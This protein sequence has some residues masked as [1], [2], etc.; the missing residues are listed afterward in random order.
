MLISRIAPPKSALYQR[1]ANKIASLDHLMDYQPLTWFGL[2]SIFAAGMA[3]KGGEID[4]YHY[5]DWSNWLIGIVI[6]LVLTY[7]VS[8]FL[9][10]PKRISFQPSS[11]PIRSVLVVTWVGM[12]LFIT[13]WKVP[14]VLNG[15]TFD[16]LLPQAGRV[17]L[18][19]IPYVL[20]F[21]AL[22]FVHSVKIDD[23]GESLP[24]VQSQS[25]RFN[26]FGI[27]FILLVFGLIFGFYLEDPVITTASA[28]SLPFVGIGFLFKAVRHVQRAKVYPIFIT[29]MFVSLREPWLLIP[30]AVLFFTLRFYHYFRYEIVYPTFAVELEE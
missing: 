24:T 25:Q 30:V 12:I 8:V 26:C 11:S 1:I 28:V 7:F 5:W 23:D 18:Y 21:A 6:L 13:G 29:A 14:F 4:R 2:W 19:M 22:A 15:F 9:L 10:K 3:A 16:D 17:F 27:A 20:M